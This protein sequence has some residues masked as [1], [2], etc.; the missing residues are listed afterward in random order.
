[1]KGLDITLGPTRVVED[2]E[3]NDY[4]KAIAVNACNDR[5]VKTLGAWRFKK[6]LESATELRDEKKQPLIR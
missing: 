2:G 4:L 5:T 3:A 6:R 1:M